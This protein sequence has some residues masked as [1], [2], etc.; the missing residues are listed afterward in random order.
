MNTTENTKLGT[1]E[2]KTYIAKVWCNPNSGN[3]KISKDALEN[4]IAEFL[5]DGKAMGTLEHPVT[6]PY[7]CVPLSEMACKVNDMWMDDNGDMTANVTPV[8]TFNGKLLESI[9]EKDPN[10]IEFELNGYYH[11]EHNPE[12]GEVETI[13]DG[14]CSINAVLG[15]HQKK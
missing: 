10:S 12:T 2:N 14:I 8:G 3:T 13:I 15:K 5:K 11:N 7:G 1:M 4:A 6:I 9:I